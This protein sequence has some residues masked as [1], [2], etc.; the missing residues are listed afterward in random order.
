MSW[1]S[2]PGFALAPAREPRRSASA[3]CLRV[4]G[5]RARYGHI[6][7][8]GGVDIEVMPGTITVVLGASG[9]GKT[10]LLRSVCGTIARE[11]VVA[12][13]DVRLDRMHA[14]AIA[15]HGV[16]RT[17]DAGATA[18]DLLAIARA[19][20]SSPRFVLMDEP[21]SGL[22]PAR[23]VELCAT[24]RA[25]VRIERLGLLLVEQNDV[26]AREVADRLYV[27]EAGRTVPAETG[28]QT[29]RRGS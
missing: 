9:A 11:G 12:L 21:S 1:S 19:L 5:L 17:S 18:P 27:L 6:E 20:A 15:R 8:L 22:A 26:F 4:R 10:T 3:H 13:G 25:I 2:D 24:L 7:V 29:R 28:H 16:V 14:E 23:A